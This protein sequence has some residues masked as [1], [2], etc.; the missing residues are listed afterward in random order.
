MTTLPI[1]LFSSPNI[2]IAL[3]ISFNLTSQQHKQPS[4]LFIVRKCW[5]FLEEDW[6]IWETSPCSG[7]PWPPLRNFLQIVDGGNFVS[8]SA[9]VL[10]LPVYFSVHATRLKI[11]TFHTFAQSMY[12]VVYLCKRCLVAPHIC[13][14]Q[15]D[16][17]SDNVKMAETWPAG[18]HKR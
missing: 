2:L 4:K 17:V 12:K 3:T 13:N 9:G 10:L 11:C 14:F 8:V 7:R 1:T 16:H 15:C 5:I 18:R 6:R